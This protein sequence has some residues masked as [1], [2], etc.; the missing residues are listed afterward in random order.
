MSYALRVMLI[1]VGL[2]ALTAAA[3]AFAPRVTDVTVVAQTP[4]G[5]NVALDSPVTVTFSRPVDTR[6][7]EH[8]FLLYPPVKGRFLWRDQTLVFQPAESLRPRTSYSVTIRP[9]L[10]DARGY[11]NRAMTSWP[12]ST[13]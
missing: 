1:A 9:G 2:A 11:I 8:A 12:F 5:A 4:N 7:A 13:Q 10:R 3:I 6:S